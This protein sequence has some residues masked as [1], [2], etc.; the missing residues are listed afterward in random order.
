M[1][2]TAKKIGVAVLGMLM[3]VCLTLGLVFLFSP[4]GASLRASADSAQEIQYLTATDSDGIQRHF[5]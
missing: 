4:T 5:H 2:N 3:A 1:N